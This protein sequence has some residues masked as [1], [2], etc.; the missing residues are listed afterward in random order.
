MILEKFN[1]T[2]WNLQWLIQDL[3]KLNTLH[4]PNDVIVDASMPNVVC[5]GGKMWNKKDEIQDYIA[6]ILAFVS[7]YNIPGDNSDAE[8]KGSSLILQ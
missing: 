6:M 5:D 2:S 1:D 7:C 8:A 4:V 3:E